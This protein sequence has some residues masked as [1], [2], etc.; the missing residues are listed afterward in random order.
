MS[1]Y[2]QLPE[3]T[4]EAIVDGWYA[5]GDGGYIED[6]GLLYLTDRIK[7]MIV[8]G[9]ENIY[10]TEIEEV[11][12]RHPAVLDAAVVG[13]PDARWGEKVCAVVQLRPGQTADVQALQTFLRTH[14]AGYKCPKHIRF[15]EG[16][17]RTASGKVRRVELRE[18]LQRG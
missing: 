16:L 12:R 17:P 9:G 8:S 5:S 10:P 13:V 7:D 1:G 4:A 11:L 6:D 2:W 14:L 18:Q 3:K 15:S